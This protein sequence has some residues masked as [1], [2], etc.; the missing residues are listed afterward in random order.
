MSSVLVKTIV[1]A[2]LLLL[3]PAAKAEGWLEWKPPT[4]AD[5]TLL[6]LSET[7]LVIDCGQTLNIK[8]H[9]GH[10]ETNPILGPHPSDTKVRV[11]FAASMATVAAGWY[12]TPAKLRPLWPI[13]ILGMEIPTIL[14]NRE[15]GLTLEF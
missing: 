1:V 9:V 5:T 12:F 10:Q 3:A 8:S 2:F 11:Y 15:V 4:M 7:S 13:L 14:H 6:A